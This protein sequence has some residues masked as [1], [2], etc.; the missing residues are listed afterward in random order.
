MKAHGTTLIELMIALMISI[1]IIGSV[2]EIYLATQAIQQNQIAMTT[3]VENSRIAKNFLKSTVAQIK[4]YDQNSYF[5]GKT[6]RFDAKGDAIYALYH[7]DSH[8]KKM[9][10]VEGVNKMKI[11][12]AVLKNNELVEHPI[13]EIT[14]WS[15]VRG[16][17]IEWVFASLNASTM[18]KTEYEYIALSQ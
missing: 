1:L 11:K 3:I 5:I 13:E 15:K 18:E 7:Q 12:Y 8:A 10:L 14:D 4:Q 9:E 2:T 16:V 6:D 17:A